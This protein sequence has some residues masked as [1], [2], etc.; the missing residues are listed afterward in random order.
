MFNSDS[1]PGAVIILSPSHD[2][3]RFSFEA[4]W[5]MKNRHTDEEKRRYNTEN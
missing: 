5:Q 2:T 4:D 3:R 1:P